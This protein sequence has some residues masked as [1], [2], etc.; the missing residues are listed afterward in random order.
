MKR[1][2]QFI[3]ENTWTDKKMSN[4]MKISIARKGQKHHVDRLVDDPSPSV[5]KAVAERGFD[6]HLRKLINDSN[7]QV[8]AAAYATRVMNYQ[9]ELDDRL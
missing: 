3:N 6:D 1:F 7:R 9:K 4:E 2:G 5:R 8:R